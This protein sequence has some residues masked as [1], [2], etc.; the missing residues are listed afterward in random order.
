MAL[1]HSGHREEA[2]TEFAEVIAC[3]ESKAEGGDEAHLE[4]A[5][6]WHARVLYELKRYEEAEP[7]LAA[8]AAGG[9]GAGSGDEDPARDARR[10]HAHSLYHLGRLDDAEAEYREVASESDR[11]LGPDH[12]ESVHRRHIHGKLLAATERYPEAEAELAEV[13]ARRTAAAEAADSADVLEAR[14]LH[15]TVLYELGLREARA[16]GVPLEQYAAAEAELAEVITA[17]TAAGNS[18]PADVLKIREQRAV[19][20]DAMGRLEETHTELRAL[21]EEHRRLHGPAHPDKLRMR[22]A[23]AETLRK[24]GLRSRAAAEYGAIARQRAMTLGPD[25]PDT[26]RVRECQDVLLRRKKPRLRGNYSV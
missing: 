22:E 6:Q 15:A 19:I 2:E 1:F 3:R 16:G 24:L 8:L 7:E 10:W 12:P 17:R 4:R 13:I 5:R 9:Q 11:V 18:D 23:R 21:A 26:R 25:H 20:M 14:E